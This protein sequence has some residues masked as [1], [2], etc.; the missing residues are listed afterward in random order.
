[1]RH[2]LSEQRC[3]FLN[4]VGRA[5]A[6][7]GVAACAL[8]DLRFGDDTDGRAIRKQR[9]VARE[10]VQIQATASFE[11]LCDALIDSQLVGDHWRQN[12]RK[13]AVERRLLEHGKRDGA[14]REHWRWQSQH[15]QLQL[16]RSRR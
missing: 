5:R 16:V 9:N 8:S 10:R 2:Y 13:R 3:P 15:R 12:T 1:M 11:L 14:V 4:R 7:P 6:P